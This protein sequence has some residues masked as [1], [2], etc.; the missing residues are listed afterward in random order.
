MDYENPKSLFTS[1]PDSVGL[2]WIQFHILDRIIDFSSYAL[3]SQTNYPITWEVNVSVD[4][5]EWKTVHHPQNN[6]IL[7]DQL[8]HIF[9]TDKSSGFVRFIKITS[10]DIANDISGQ[11]QLYLFNVDFYGSSYQCQNC[12][13]PP[14]MRTWDC[15]LKKKYC[16]SIIFFF[17]SK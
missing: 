3:S 11:D 15:L 17:P 13:I 9:D 2:N 8:G 16:F 1:I 7:S 14:F 5:K 4:G 6:Y 12:I 10:L